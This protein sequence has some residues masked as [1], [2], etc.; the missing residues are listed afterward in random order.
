MKDCFIGLSCA[1][2]QHALLTRFNALIW[3]LVVV[4]ENHPD[5]FFVQSVATASLKNNRL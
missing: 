2:Y 3:C 1:K 5:T 4:H